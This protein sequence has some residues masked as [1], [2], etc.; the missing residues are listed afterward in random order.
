MALTNNLIVNIDE[1]DQIK[2]GKQAELKQMLSKIEVN[3]RPIFGKVQRTRRRFASFVATTNNP[4]PLNDP[5][6]SRRYLCVEIP[7]DSLIDTW[8][9]IDYDQLY[10]QVLYEV[11]NQ[12]LPYWFTNEEV[13]AI[14]QHNIGYQH[15]NDLE[16]MLT[17]CFRHPETNEV[18]LPLQTR[19][20]VGILSRSFPEI[21]RTQGMNIKVGRL[22]KAMNFERKE[23]AQGTVYYL[24][25]IASAA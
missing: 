4:R 8:S 18:I 13:R 6:G 24:V 17:T 10:A 25:P 19:D 2:S 3:G 23:I 21:Q 22:L 15:V 12:H 14:E 20:I 1:L 5:T 9:S 16:S 7:R 11:R